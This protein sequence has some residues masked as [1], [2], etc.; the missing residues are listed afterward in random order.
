M[1]SQICQR[2]HK[3]YQGYLSFSMIFKEF[4]RFCYEFLWFSEVSRGCQWIPIISLGFSAFQNFLWFP[5]VSLSFQWFTFVSQSFPT[6]I[7]V[8]QEFL[9][10]R[11]VSHIAMRTKIPWSSRISTLNAKACVEKAKILCIANN[12]IE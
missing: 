5:I 3:V 10:F 2:F 9:W 4:S 8:F 1:F 7:I 6:L 11:K 12:C